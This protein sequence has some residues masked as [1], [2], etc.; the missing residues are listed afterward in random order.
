LRSRARYVL[1]LLR[2]DIILRTY[3]PGD[4]LVEEALSERY[5]VSRQP[6]REAIRVLDAEGYVVIAPHRGATVA[7]VDADEAR[8]VLVVRAAV[9]QLCALR[10]AQ[11]ASAADADRLADIVR[12]GRAAHRAGDLR[13]ETALDTAYLSCLASLSAS[14]ALAQTLRQ[15]CDTIEWLF[16]AH[17]ARWDD[18]WRGYAAV[19]GAIAVGDAESAAALMRSELTD[20]IVDYRFRE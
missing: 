10:A 18:V 5:D 19:T 8:D 12:R 11:N 9:G 15:L 7:V 17:G 2:R 6:V 3:A 1:A 16:E 13:D 14:D 4:H 20:R